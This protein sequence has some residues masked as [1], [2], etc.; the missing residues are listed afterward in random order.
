M[1][2]TDDAAS[3]A[4]LDEDSPSD[5]VEAGE[6]AARDNTAAAAR[7]RLYCMKNGGK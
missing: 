6:Q 3:D 1:T 2:E 4:A 5:V 7:M